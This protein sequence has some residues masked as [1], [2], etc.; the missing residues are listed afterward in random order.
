[1]DQLLLS[2]LACGENLPDVPLPDALPRLVHSNGSAG[3]ERTSPR[4]AE[5]AM[6][7]VFWLGSGSFLV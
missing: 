2:E 4:V 7:V 6:G 3:E 5:E 1:V